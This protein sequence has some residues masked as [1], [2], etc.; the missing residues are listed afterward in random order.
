M[1]TR[2]FEKTSYHVS[3]EGNITIDERNIIDDTVIN[4]GLYAAWSGN[5]VDIRCVVSGFDDPIFR[6]LFIREVNAK[7]GELS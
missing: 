3:F 5:I 7:L 1:K 4:L 6:K 2:N